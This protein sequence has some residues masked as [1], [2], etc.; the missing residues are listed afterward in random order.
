[1]KSRVTTY[2]LVVAVLAVWGFIAWKFF[3]SRP[4][5]TE[6]APVRPAGRETPA[7]EEYV[8]TLDYPDPF[9]KGAFVEVLE[10]AYQTTEP[11]YYEPPYVYD[12]HPA[13]VYAGTISTGGR[14]SHIFE[15]E[16]LLHPLSQGETLDGY[17]LTKVF[18]DSVMLAK[19]GAI[20]TIHKQRD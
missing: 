1:M 2:L 15:H 6:A 11:T 10:T 5:T 4:D 19:E 17:T 18:P 9:L 3:F 12:E 8:L 20:F 7:H 14:V 16:G 13:I